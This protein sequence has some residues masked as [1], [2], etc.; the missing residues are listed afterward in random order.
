MPVKPDAMFPILIIIELCVSEIFQR[1]GTVF[2]R[3][4]PF[5]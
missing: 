5:L 2:K 4:V 3:V 1:K